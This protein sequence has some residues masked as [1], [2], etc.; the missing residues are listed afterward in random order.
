MSE[1][2]G[3]GMDCLFMLISTVLLDYLLYFIIIVLVV[4]MVWAMLLKRY[5]NE[6][7]QPGHKECVCWLQPPWEDRASRPHNQHIL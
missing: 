4:E 6:G 3:A 7:V 1:D 5:E 2:G